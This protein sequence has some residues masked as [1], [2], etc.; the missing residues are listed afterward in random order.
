MSLREILTLSM[1]ITLENIPMTKVK[2]IELVENNDNISAEKLVSPLLR[3]ILANL[4][5]IQASVNLFAL[6]KKFGEEDL[7]KNIEILESTKLRTNDIAILAVGSCLLT[8]EKKENLKQLLKSTKDGAFLLSREK[9]NIP[10]DYSIL[11]EF[12]LGIVLEKRTSEELWILLRKIEEI[13]KNILFINVRSNEFNCLKEVQDVLA[14]E[15]Q[16]DNTRVIFVEEGNFESGLLGFINCLQKETGGKIFRA[17]LVQ[18]LTAPKFSLELPLYSEQFETDLFMNVLRPGN[19][20]G[21]YRHQLLP[22]REPK[23]M[24]HAFVN[25]LSRGDL[26]ALRWLEGPITKDYQ[27]KNLVRIHYS[28][29][30]FKDVMLATGKIGLDVFQQ[31]RKDVD[32][33]LGF[34]YSGIS[35]GGRRIMGLN[36][37]KCLSNLYQMDEIFSWTVPESWSLENAATVPCIYSTCIDALYINGEIKKGDRIL[38]HFGAG[39]VG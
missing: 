17:V 23:L 4:R 6:P 12:R 13:S 26:I 31:I 9:E 39:G 1:H 30:N 32:N 8:N 24:Y 34:E 36:P 16:E 33:V 11:K 28:S 18:D 5:S 3:D 37:N 19:V 29:L 35:I 15:T 25:Q 27:K 38:I 10:L 20:W 21:S 22:S 2:T 14:N 7:L